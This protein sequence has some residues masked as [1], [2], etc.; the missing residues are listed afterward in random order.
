MNKPEVRIIYHLGMF[1]GQ[2]VKDCVLLRWDKVD[3]KR[4]R[5]E[6]KQFKTGK[7]VSIPMA[8]QLFEVFKGGSGG[9]KKICTFVRMLPSTTT[10]LIKTARM[11]EII[12]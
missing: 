4:K 6:S 2:G 1:T 3:F 5:I 10:S 8:A 11:S 12:W 7:E 9:G